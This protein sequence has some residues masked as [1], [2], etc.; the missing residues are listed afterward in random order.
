MESPSEYLGEGSYGCVVK[1]PVKCINKKKL[2]KDKEDNSVGKIF[3]KKQ[4]FDKEIKT[5]KIAIK[6]DK[7][8][9]YLLTANSHCK[10]NPKDIQKTNRVKL[11][12]FKHNHDNT[13]YQL[14]MPYG[15]QI[16]KDYIK[17]NNINSINDLLLLAVNLFEGLQLLEKHKM[18]HQ[19]I[20]PDNI[21]VKPIGKAVLIDF[22]LMIPFNTIYSEVNRNRLRYSYYPYPPEY[23][24]YE[25]IHFQKCYNYDY[26]FYVLNAYINDNL[27]ILSNDKHLK[28]LF[29]DKE[30][31]D[32]LKPKITS[33]I[34]K[35]KTKT[36]TKYIEKYTNKIDT[37]SL[38]ITLVKLLKY[39]N[40]D[41]KNKKVNEFLRNIIHPDFEK[42]YSPKQAIQH[43]KQLVR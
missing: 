22:T 33:M 17:Y 11:C 7:T 18:C 43:I 2:K 13:Y 10:L 12:E 29:T 4:I 14:N 38:G 20:K 40:Y 15:G 6:I 28:T 35:E 8:N 32:I 1:P 21:L 9:N 23:K 36:L 30:I 31:L 34:E 16:I 5:N 25:Y 3:I 19:D 39:I 42:R 24:I 27:S 37:Y 41:M 26:C